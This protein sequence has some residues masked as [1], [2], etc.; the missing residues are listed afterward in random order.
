MTLL[1]LVLPAVVNAQFTFTTNTDGS[2]NIYDYTGPNTLVSLV[3][4]SM[5]NG[6][7]VT[8]IGEPQ[9]PPGVGLFGGFPSLQNVTFNTN[10]VAL[11]QDMFAG[12]R[13]LTNITLPDSLLSIGQGTFESSGLVS[14]TI[15]NG[16][17]NIADYAFQDCGSLASVTIGTNVTSIGF[18]AFEYCTSLASLTIPDSVITMG[19]FPF[20]G[21]VGL[22]NV[23]IGHGLTSIGSGLFAA[24][25]NLTSIIIP[26]NITNIGGS[27]FGNCS[28]LSSVMIGTNVAIISPQAF[29]G[30]TSL[31]N[32][33][34]PGSVTNIGD[35]TFESCN[36]DWIFFAGNAPV[37][38]SSVFY[39]TAP[40]AYYLPGATGWATFNANSGLSPAMLWNPQAQTG[41]GRFG[42]QNNQFGFNITGTTNIPIVVEANTN[43]SNG[44]WTPLQSCLVTNGSV[45]FSDPQWTNYPE[46][47]YRLS[48]P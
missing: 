40:T 4:P 18:L 1:V 31:T 29:Y 46:R 38:G 27:A 8:T 5:T 2:L 23:V 39:A 14:A 3:I 33:V 37:L 42:V 32:I 47:Y 44:V 26:N 20:E 35:Q 12:C 6:L 7:P 36:L 43:L 15:G 19:Q 25:T 28:N 22:T 16:E 30:C 13:A 41:D 9:A 24:C 11:G 21:C 17:T 10:L 45:Y 34:I 48:S